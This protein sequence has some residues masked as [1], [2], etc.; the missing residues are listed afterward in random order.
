MNEGDIV[1]HVPFDYHNPKLIKYVV[2]GTVN[3]NPGD[4]AIVVKHADSVNDDSVNGS[5]IFN[6]YS[7]LHK[8]PKE[9][10]L[11]TKSCIEYAIQRLEELID[12]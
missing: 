5:L 1:W 4:S 2:V 8:T 3:R 7:E 12:E 11:H 6:W 10:I 9:A